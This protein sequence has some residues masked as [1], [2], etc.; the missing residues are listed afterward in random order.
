MKKYGKSKQ[1]KLKYNHCNVDLYFSVERFQN[2]L[3]DAKNICNGLSS[4]GSSVSVRPR[5]N[6]HPSLAHTSNYDMRPIIANGHTHNSTKTLEYCNIKE[7]AA[8]N[9]LSS[10][11]TEDDGTRNE[12]EHLNSVVDL[13][14]QDMTHASRANWIKYLNN[15]ISNSSLLS[16]LLTEKTSTSCDYE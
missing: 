8:W 10:I 12:I 9:S 16:Y 14:M 1:I 2:R 11:M 5:P 13:I 6:Y 4:V 3:I 7:S 15:Q